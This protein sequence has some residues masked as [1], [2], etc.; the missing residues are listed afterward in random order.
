M[1]SIRS[2]HHNEYRAVTCCSHQIYTPDVLLLFKE[3]SHVKLTSSLFVCYSI[4]LSI[5][6]VILVSTFLACHNIISSEYFSKRHEKQFW[7]FFAVGLRSSPH[8]LGSLRAKT[9]KMEQNK[10]C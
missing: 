9:P 7:L 2:C 1:Q 5:Y 3:I 6:F 8:L 4:L 10:R